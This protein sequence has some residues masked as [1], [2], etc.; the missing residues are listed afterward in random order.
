MPGVKTRES[1][2]I[3]CAIEYARDP[4]DAKKQ[5]LLVAAIKFAKAKATMADRRDAW[6]LRTR[7]PITKG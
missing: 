7:L 5:A 1:G 6:K 4:N 2:L 3:D